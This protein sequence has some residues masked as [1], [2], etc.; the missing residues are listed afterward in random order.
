VKLPKSTLYQ[1]ATIDAYLSS[2][3]FEHQVDERAF[4][5]RPGREVR[6]RSARPRGFYIASLAKR[7]YSIAL[8]YTEN[9][10]FHS[11]RF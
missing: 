10:S 6:E 1:S 5:P 4:Q 2:F 9:K 3:V 8:R 7:R 11:R